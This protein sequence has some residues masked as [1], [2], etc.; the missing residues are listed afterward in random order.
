MLTLVEYSNC[1]AKLGAQFV[2][3]VLASEQAF[4]LAVEKDCCFTEYTF[5][6][7]VQ[8]DKLNDKFW[9]IKQNK[10]SKITDAIP[11]NKSIINTIL[12]CC[13]NGPSHDQ[14]TFLS[15]AGNGRVMLHS[16]AKLPWSSTT[17][18]LFE[19]IHYLTILQ[20]KSLPQFGRNEGRGWAH[21]G[22]EC[23]MHTSYNLVSLKMN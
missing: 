10:A 16:E 2:E 7:I 22:W 12:V 5:A 21:G 20:S 11:T 4:I 15:P 23:I 17:K 1:S 13:P 6:Q 9:L 18:W 19:V 3:C 14:S 8:R